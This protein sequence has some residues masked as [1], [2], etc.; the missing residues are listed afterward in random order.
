MCIYV[1][2]TGRGGE[3]LKLITRSTGARIVCSRKKKHSPG[4]KGSV[5][6]TGSKQEVKQ[7]KVND[8]FGFYKFNSLFRVR[9]TAI[10][11]TCRR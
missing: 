9:L 1:C 8:S 7:A 11:L 3:C 6:I 10:F 5:T 2:V 4:E